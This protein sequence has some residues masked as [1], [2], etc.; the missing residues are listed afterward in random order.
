MLRKYRA[1]LEEAAEKANISAA[2]IEAAIARD[3]GAWIREERLPK[4]PPTEI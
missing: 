1:A 2:L 3:F 4:P